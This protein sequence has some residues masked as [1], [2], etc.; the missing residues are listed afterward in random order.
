MGDSEGRGRERAGRRGE[1][2]GRTEVV[3]EKGGKRKGARGDHGMSFAWLLQ[4]GGQGL[5]WGCSG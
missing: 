4:E 5:P 3:S 1:G 2:E